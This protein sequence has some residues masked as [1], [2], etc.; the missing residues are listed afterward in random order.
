MQ[1]DGGLA[2]NLIGGGFLGLI[3]GFVFGS[4]HISSF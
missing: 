4:S 1:L 3:G 2:F